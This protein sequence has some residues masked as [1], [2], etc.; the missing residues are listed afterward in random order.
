MQFLILAPRLHISPYARGINCL[1]MR[2]AHTVGSPSL[3]VPVH[4]QVY[5]VPTPSDP[6]GS[7]N[8]HLAPI[9]LI[10]P[11]RQSGF[12]RG[13]RIKVVSPTSL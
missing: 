5:G 1:E 9:Y 13:S 12:R 3:F 8:S 4:T 11:S 7:L 2:S 6:P 10:G